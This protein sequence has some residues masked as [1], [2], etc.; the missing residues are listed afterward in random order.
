MH[1]GWPAQKNGEAGE[2][3]Q[4]RIAPRTRIGQADY[5]ADYENV[6]DPRYPRPPAAE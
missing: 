3:R 6:L 4:P 5:E 2:E 1:N